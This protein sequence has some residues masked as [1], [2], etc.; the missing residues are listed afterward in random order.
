[1]ATIVIVHGAGTGG[2]LWQGV[3][4]H[5]SAAGHEAYTPTLTG[6]G[7]RAHLAR[8]E[9]DLN[10]HIMDITGVLECEDKG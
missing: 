1:M 2:W 7:E 5:L 6:V 10:T 4:R 8:P 9:I 3:R